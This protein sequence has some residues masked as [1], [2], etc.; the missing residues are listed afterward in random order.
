MAPKTRTANVKPIPKSSKKKAAST[1]HVFDIDTE[2]EEE[3]DHHLTVNLDKLEKQF[4][5]LK[6]SMADVTKSFEFMSDSFD[7]VKAQLK[8]LSSEQKRMRNEIDRLNENEKMMK[9]RIER[10]EMDQ[11]KSNQKSNENH[12]IIT[13]VPKLETEI[14]EAVK[15]IGEQVG[16]TIETSE[17][18][19]A[20]QGEN[21]KF[22][23]HPLI[24]K[25]KTGDFKKKCMEF[26][27]QGHKID[28]KLFA[29][30]ADIGEKNIN[31][32]PLLEK[33]IVDLLKQT[34]NTAKK[35]AYKF[36]WVSGSNVFARKGEATP[37][38]KI[39][40][41]EDLKKIN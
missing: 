29:P 40:S 32:H 7:N 28:V 37:I 4:R 38:I 30:N 6:K 13:N 17:I 5:D 18:I 33:E 34:K 1:S 3:E 16:C 2:G 27:K 41:T 39:N 19:D 8:Q 15:K 10:L 24:V 22:K 23:T 14:K 9:K 25:L 36:V 26:R 35:K 20:Y 12:V 31:F 11:A 21:K